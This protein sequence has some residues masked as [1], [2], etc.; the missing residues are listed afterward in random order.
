MSRIFDAL[1]RSGLEQTGVEYPDMMTVAKGITNAAVPILFSQLAPSRSSMS[2]QLRLGGAAVDSVFAPKL[3][4]RNGWDGGAIRA[5]GAAGV[6]SG[7]VAF[8]IAGSASRVGVKGVGICATVL[9]G[10]GA[11]IGGA[12]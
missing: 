10:S 2:A 8:G 9:I 11:G 12:G 6:T 3:G 7:V 4:A 5:A 1:Q